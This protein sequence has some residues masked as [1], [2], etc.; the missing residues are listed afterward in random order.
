[1]INHSLHLL[2][3]IYDKWRIM[4]TYGVCVSVCVSKI[5]GVSASKQVTHT[6]IPAPVCSVSASVVNQWS[7]R[8]LLTRH[9]ISINY[10]QIIK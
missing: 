9:S 4:S 2:K 10:V 1:M 3:R 8:E 7:E 6:S 5:Y